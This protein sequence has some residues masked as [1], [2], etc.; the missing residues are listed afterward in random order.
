MKICAVQIKS[1]KG[2]IENNIENHKKWMDVAIFEKADFI[3]FPELSLT[4]YEPEIAKELATDQYDERLEE[5]QKISDLNEIVIGV[6]LPTKSELGILISMVIFQPSKTRRTYSKQILHSDE[7]PY[8]IEGNEQIILTVK[9]IKIALAI[10]YESLQP[11]HSENA[12]I[13]SGIIFGE[14]CKIPNWN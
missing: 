5:F 14:C 6:G 9:D 4:G 10:C 12:D 8:F 11:E 7:K 2:N 1:E 3:F 13:R